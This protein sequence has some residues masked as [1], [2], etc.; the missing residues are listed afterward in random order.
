MWRRRKKMLSSFRPWEREAAAESWRLA[1]E[2]IWFFFL[3][4]FQ[5]KK[6]KRNNRW[7]N[8]VTVDSI[9]VC[10]S[11]RALMNRGTCL[12]T[13]NFTKW[14]E[15]ECVCVCVY[16]ASVCWCMT[17]WA[18]YKKKKNVLF[19]FSFSFWFIFFCHNKVFASAWSG[20]GAG[21]LFFFFFSLYITDL[22]T[23]FGNKSKQIVTDEPTLSGSSTMKLA[24]YA[25][26]AY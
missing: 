24:W 14:C 6:K 8:A 2:L 9:W 13:C 1:D 4:V 7:G 12:D 20:L 26:C 22:G 16:S 5:K 23:R 17:E 3:S 15:R 10:G 25:N 21:L 18:Y 11:V 19:I